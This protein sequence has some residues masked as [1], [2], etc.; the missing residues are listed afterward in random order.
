[1]EAF[2]TDNTVHYDHFYFSFSLSL[3]QTKVLDFDL[4]ETPILNQKEKQTGKNKS[5][6]IRLQYPY[7]FDVQISIHFSYESPLYTECMMEILTRVLTVSP[8]ASIMKRG[9]VPY[10]ICCCRHGL[11]AFNVPIVRKTGGLA[12]TVFDMD[13]QSH[14][15]IANGFVFEGIDEGSLN[16]ALGRAFSYYQETPNEWKAVVQKAMRIDNS[17]NNTAGKYIDIYNSTSVAFSSATTRLE[18]R[19]SSKNNIKEHHFAPRIFFE[20]FGNNSKMLR[21]LYIWKSGKEDQKYQSFYM[22]LI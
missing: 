13:D 19:N 14:T 6:R 9:A 4:K 7:P 21:S 15:E 17:W 12:D 3:F 2:T 18:L 8:M 5:D 1:M 22:G 20:C 16:C 10:A 11:G